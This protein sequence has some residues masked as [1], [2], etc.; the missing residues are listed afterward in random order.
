MEKSAHFD[1]LTY[2]NATFNLANEPFMLFVFKFI[3][4]FNRGKE[5]R[6]LVHFRLPHR[7][8]MFREVVSDR[9]V[10]V[11]LIN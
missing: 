6:F 5:I 3:F 2:I 7:Q 4:L 9:T 1:I 10:N 8:H 11:V